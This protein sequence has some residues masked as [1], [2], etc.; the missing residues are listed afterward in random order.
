M[1]DARALIGKTKVLWVTLDTLRYDVA[2]GCLR[3]G[4]T[5]HLA[6]HLPGQ[7]WEERHSPASFTLAAHYA[8]FHGFLPTPP[9]GPSERLFAVRFAGSETTGERTMVF[10][11][12]SVPA[13]LQARGYRTVCI[14]GTG[15]FNPD[16]PL[17]AV[18]PAFFGEAHWS[19]EMSVTG[20]DSTRLQVD[21]ALDILQGCD[22]D[23]FLFL[24]VSAL[25]QPN[26]HY[27]GL[28]VDCVESQAAALAYC[29]AHLGRLLDGFQAHGPTLVVLTSD[30]GTCYGEDGLHGHRL[31]HPLVWTVPYAEFVL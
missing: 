25:H 30:H 28:T 31:G 9:E 1:L 3:A 12:P 15:F 14:G 11:E 13:A 4:R 6:R 5:P 18:L 20:K 2:L 21:L 17:G 26:A 8:F 7:A 16:Q 23:L 27:A 10:D 22:S 24:N 29:D 19:P